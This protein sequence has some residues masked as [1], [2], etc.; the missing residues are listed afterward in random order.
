[1]LWG[2]GLPE[3]QKIHSLVQQSLQP[4]VAEPINFHLLAHSGA[5]LGYKEDGSEDTKQLPRLH[6]E[7]PT[8]YPT[9]LQQLAEVD[10][11]QDEI[12]PAE[13][14]DVVVAEGSVN[15]VSIMNILDP[16]ITSGRL[17]RLIETYCHQHMKRLLE[18]VAAKFP[19]AIIIV[20][21]YYP[22]LNEHSEDEYLSEILYAVG[23][24][25][26]GLIADIP[27]DFIA[28]LAKKKILSNCD[29]FHRDS[30]VALQ[31][32]VDEVN[33]QLGDNPRLFL[34]VPDFAP[35]N[36]MNAPDP[37]LFAIN[38][39]MTP[40][41]VLFKERCELCEE[42]G[43]SRTVVPICKR[44]SNGHPNANGARAYADAIVGALINKLPDKLKV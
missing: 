14:V 3:E 6:G 28:R 32:A 24:R 37:Y 8:F 17:K 34:V 40:Q 42:A 19:N 12:G 9:L 30:Q 22:M 44:A 25:P 4:K 29:L 10:T 41:D 21:A 11:R 5:V 20:P 27:I 31:M 36:T 35:H 39:D 26:G 13:E 7:V 38:P 23:A 1:V 33:A 2:Q 18:R 16:F 43:N 15:D